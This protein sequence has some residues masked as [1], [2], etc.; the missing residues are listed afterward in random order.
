MNYCDSC[1]YNIQDWTN[2][3]NLDC[4]CSNPTSWN[5]GYNTEF[6]DKC[7]DWESNDD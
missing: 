7:D 1:R 5:Y 6:I 4:Y 2:K 3:D